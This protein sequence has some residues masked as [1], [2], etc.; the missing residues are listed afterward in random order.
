MNSQGLQWDLIQHAC[1]LRH[2]IHLA[3]S[4]RSDIL[5]LSDLH[6]RDLTLHV[7]YIEEY[8]LVARGAVGLLLRH[9]AAA[10]WEAE[11]R[12]AVWRGDSHRLLALAIT[13]HD[14]TVSHVSNYSPTGPLVGPKRDHYS[15]AAALSRQLREQDRPQ[16][17]GGD[18]NAHIGSEDGDG[19]LVGSRGLSTPT[20]AGGRLLKEF[21]QTT[22]LRH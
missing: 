20:T 15:H 2:L 21:L 14:R 12:A 8:V 3:R 16:I 5:F 19:R 22:T 4:Q 6:Y 13:A 9:C 18:F 10:L 11:G 7:V 17:W 1:K